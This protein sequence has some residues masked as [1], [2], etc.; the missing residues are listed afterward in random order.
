MDTVDDVIN[1]FKVSNGYFS[2]P[3]TENIAPHIP[4]SKDGP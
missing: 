3:G 2:F 4:A 1:A